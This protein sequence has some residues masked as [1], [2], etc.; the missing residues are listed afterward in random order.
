MVT[1]KASAPT[2]TAAEPVKAVVTSSTKA[3]Q[4]PASTPVSNTAS[5]DIQSY[6]D[7]HNNERANHGAVALV[8]N[9]TLADAAQN[10]ANQCTGTHSGG[11]L[12]PYGEN[13]STGTGNFT[14]SAAVQLWLNEAP[15]YDPSNPQPSH[16]TQV[17]WKGTTN[18]GCAVAECDNLF[19]FS[20][21]GRT[22]YYVCEYYPAGNVLGEF[23][24]NVQA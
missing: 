7:L 4:T 12:G 6:L 10:W 8:W 16:W 15:Q 13:L 17:V 19:D 5:S 2:T 21:F 3:A 23:A 20:K 22:L 11:S 1:S 24:Q 18:L 14:I 9:N